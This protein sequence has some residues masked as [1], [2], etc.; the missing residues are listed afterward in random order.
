MRKALVWFVIVLVTCMFTACS[1]SDSKSHKE[2]L[3]EKEVAARS[4]LNR[5]YAHTPG[6]RHLAAGAKAV[7]VFPE[8]TK[9]GFLVG[10]QFGNGVLF[11]DGRVD[12][13]YRSTAASYGLQAGA[14]KFGYALFFMTE[15][16]LD[17]LTESDGWEVGVGPSITVV[18]EGFAKSFTTT[19]A[20]KGVYVFFFEQKGLM[21]GLGIQGTKITKTDGVG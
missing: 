17:Y 11:K 14:Q 19:T 20:R 3:R 1:V 8:V 13:Y 7:L 5:L 12:G 15:K 18:D 2:V 10:G 9:A 4:A 16:D 6:A 21:A